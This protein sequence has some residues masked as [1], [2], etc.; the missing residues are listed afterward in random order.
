MRSGV[1]ILCGALMMLVP[2][3]LPGP[4]LALGSYAAVKHTLYCGGLRRQPKDPLL[5][6]SVQ[7]P[8]AGWT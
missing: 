5:R 4:A 1:G 6:L 7:W 3:W 2:G 8:I